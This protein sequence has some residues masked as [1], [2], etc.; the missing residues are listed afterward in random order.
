MKAIWAVDLIAFE[1]WIR[2]RLLDI[3]TGQQI[4]PFASI[5]TAA[6][7]QAWE[8][9]HHPQKIHHRMTVLLQQAGTYKI[10]DHPDKNDI[11]IFKAALSVVAWKQRNSLTMETEI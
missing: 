8:E 6:Y 7:K 9:M 2:G 1:A 10:E 3:K 5:Q 4:H 11:N